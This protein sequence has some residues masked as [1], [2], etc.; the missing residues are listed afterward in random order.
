MNSFNENKLPHD[1]F[2]DIL[3][4][5]SNGKFIKYGAESRLYH[6][7]F[8]NIINLSKLSE[9]QKNSGWLKRFRQDPDILIPEIDY[10]IELHVGSIYAKKIISSNIA[11]SNYKLSMLKNATQTEQEN[12]CYIMLP[13]DVI[14]S[15][16]INSGNC[17]K[18][19]IEKHLF[20]CLIIPGDKLLQ[21]IIRAVDK[22]Y[23]LSCVPGFWYK[24]EFYLKQLLKGRKPAFSDSHILGTKDSSS[25]YKNYCES[26]NLLWHRFHT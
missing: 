11:V 8:Y 23:S 6:K 7:E 20:T 15:D 12:Y 24:G 14:K 18:E 21:S 5:K 17:T 10:V 16:K 2:V 4:E 13:E 22:K 1:Y 26:L 3:I 19:Q 25:E 9:K